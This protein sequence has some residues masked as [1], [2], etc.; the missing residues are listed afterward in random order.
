MLLTREFACR[1]EMISLIERR[2][3]F[4]LYTGNISRDESISAR[5]RQFAKETTFYETVCYHQ[6]RQ[7][8][9]TASYLSNWT[10]VAVATGLVSS[11]SAYEQAKRQS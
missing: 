5:A 1:N 4:L 11:K 10:S 9:S 3:T 6:N 2:F 8:S 7:D